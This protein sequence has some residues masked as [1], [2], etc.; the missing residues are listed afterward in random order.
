MLGGYN[1]VA[2][3]NLKAQKIVYLQ[4]DLER[5]TDKTLFEMY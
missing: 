4:L 1:C 2:F 3:M 5:S